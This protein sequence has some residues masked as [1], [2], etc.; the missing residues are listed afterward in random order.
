LAKP[1]DA[2]SLA[3][4]ILSILQDNELAETLR[5]RGCERV[6][7]YYWDQLIPELE[8]LFTAQLR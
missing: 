1:G 2:N 4:A 3:D 6:E 7:S 8:T 5:S